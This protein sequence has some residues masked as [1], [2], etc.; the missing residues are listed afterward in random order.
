MRAG[1]LPTSFGVGRSLPNAEAPAN[2]SWG[3]AIRGFSRISF[4]DWGFHPTDG[5]SNFLYSNTSF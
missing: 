2:R 1:L 5:I 3:A 4:P